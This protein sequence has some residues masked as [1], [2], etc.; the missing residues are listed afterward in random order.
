MWM[1]RSPGEIVDVVGEEVAAREADQLAAGV[2]P[3]TVEQAGDSG[4]TKCTVR[5]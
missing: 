2:L 1:Y 3:A 4:L 5:A